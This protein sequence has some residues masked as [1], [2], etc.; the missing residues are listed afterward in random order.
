VTEQASNS[1][2]RLH[3]EDYAEPFETQDLDHRGLITMAGRRR[4]SLSGRWVFTLDP[5]EEGLRQAWHKDCWQPLEGR[6]D[7][8]DYDIHNDETIQLPCCWNLDRPE[9]FHYEGTAWFGRHLDDLP[10]RPDERLFLRIG[11]AN[12]DAKLFLDGQF[13]GHHLGG[14]TPFFV[15]LT[16]RVQPG[17]F[18][19]IAVNNSGRAERV[20][21]HH[22]DWFNYGGLF[23]EIDLIVLPDV[24][25]RQSFIRLERDRIAINVDLSDPI[26]GDLRLAIDELGIEARLTVKEGRVEATLDVDLICWS[27]DNPKLYDVTLTF[28]EDRIAERIGFRI[29]ETQGRSIILNGE[30][31]FLKG[32]AVHEDDV[33]NG[34]CT[35]D[36]DIR[37]RLSHAKDL[38]CN[39]LRLA[40]YPHHERVAEIADEIGML[41]WEEIPV[42]WAIDFD[43]PAT[44]ADARNQ[45]AE[46]MIRDRNRVSVIAWGIGNEN[47]DTA[48]RLAFMSTLAE[49]ARQRDPSRLVGAACLVNKKARRLEDRLAQKLD[50]VG[51]N[52]YYGWYDPDIQDLVEIVEQFPLEKPI[53]ITESGADAPAGR[54]GDENTMYSEAH[55][56]AY[57]RRQLE[58]VAGLDGLSGFCAWLLYDFRTMRRFASYQ[59]GFNRKGLIAEDKATR[60][61]AFVALKE[62]FGA[63]SRR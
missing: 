43:N 22:I 16:D 36:D 28:G 6:T 19:H 59:K 1:W 60:K 14:S 31:I 25:I 42:Y 46:L 62:A 53:V 56:A 3:D 48:P 51:I 63:L 45:L 35:D 54:M 30:P 4:H 15:E 11:A 9:L 44:L 47:A 21:M 10:R 29:I 23:R 27:P 57:F 40:H 2:D 41:L 52:E 33:A 26:N 24:F 34:R 18:L 13:I 58:V 61:A 49:D 55:Q 32:I 37:R 50:L 17:S 39:F 5:F 7:P 12:A 38:G 8:W 20:P